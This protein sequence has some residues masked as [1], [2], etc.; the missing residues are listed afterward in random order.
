MLLTI[1]KRVQGHTVDTMAAGTFAMMDMT[2]LRL[3]SM[4]VW[5]RILGT[6]SKTWVIFL[7]VAVTFDRKLKVK[8]IK[9]WFV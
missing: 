1:R 9:G 2:G 7:T 8:S 6:N 4:K 5:W 3:S